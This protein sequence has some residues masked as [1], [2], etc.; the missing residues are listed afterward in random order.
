MF[1]YLFME[2]KGTTKNWAD[3]KAVIDRLDD[4]HRMDER[5]AAAACT[6]LSV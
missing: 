5:A 3:S 2:D 1:K 6:V 4:I